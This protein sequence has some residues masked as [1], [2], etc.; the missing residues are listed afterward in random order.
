MSESDIVF[1]L[2]FPVETVCLPLPV[3]L[4]LPGH[5]H[6]LQSL[7]THA[8]FQLAIMSSTLSDLALAI[9][10]LIF[11]LSVFSSLPSFSFVVLWPTC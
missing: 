8:S 11:I 6:E 10:F 5:W 2:G 4:L 9:D 1:V 3:S 7:A